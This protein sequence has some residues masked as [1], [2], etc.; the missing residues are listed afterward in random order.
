MLI[1]YTILIRSAG[2]E[3]PPEYSDRNLIVKTHCVKQRWLS[4]NC[5]ASLVVCQLQD[6]TRMANPFITATASATW[7]IVAVL[8]YVLRLLYLSLILIQQSQLIISHFPLT[9]DLSPQNPRFTCRPVRMGFVVD[10]VTLGHV[11]LWVFWFFL[12]NIILL[13][14]HTHSFIWH[15]HYVIL[16]TVSVL[17]WSA[18]VRCTKWGLK[19]HQNLELHEKLHHIQNLQ[20]CS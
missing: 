3:F 20:C 14:L 16:A 19:I 10:R 4:G 13:M 18:L 17:K 8:L 1:S 5:R 2:A 12:I 15:W 7:H 9:L 6:M 11:F